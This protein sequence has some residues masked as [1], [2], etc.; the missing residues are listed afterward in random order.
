MSAN[1]PNP[2]AARQNDLLLWLAGALVAG[3]GVTWLLISSPWATRS[4]DVPR[5]APAAAA[6]AVPSNASGAASTASPPP[7]SEAAGSAAA[8]SGGAAEAAR[9]GAT[10]GLGTIDD[11]PLKMADLAY[12]AG[13]L[14]EPE[15]YSAWTLYRRALAKQP[16]NAAAKQG[17]EKIADELLRRATAAVEQGRFDDA[18][19]T[20][21]R[22]RAALPANS[23]ANDLAVKL[24]RLAPQPVLTEPP[25]VSKVV[26]AQAPLPAPEPARAE[27][28]ESK[29]AA[30]PKPA[31]PKVD[32]LA[33][34]HDAFVAAMAANRLLTPAASSAKHFVDALVAL[35][36]SS[37]V[38][39]QARSELAT[40]LLARAD[41]SLTTGD[42][43]AATT[44]IDQAS[45]LDV[46][47]SAVAAARQRLT[48]QLVKLESA[49]RLPTSEF[50]VVSYTAP[51]YPQRAL[52]RGLS[53]W[54]DVE[55]TI[56]RDGTT[57]DIVVTDAANEGYFKDAAVAAVRKW[58]FEPRVFMNRTIAQRT[59]TRINFNFK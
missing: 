25:R 37:D 50:K 32:R 14:V 46:D 4:P 36:P 16:D 19:K 10:T 8:D 12:R 57:R 59:Y 35:A 47:A 58:R 49:R 13:M 44:W 39:R 56:G 48:D 33:E 15:D 40:K 6:S 53:G 38:T 1:T 52:Q 18:R 45:S 11:D 55:F 43:D 17:L 34:A 41:E 31:E 9:Q 7:A 28:R 5:A 24:Q 30:S 29:P 27:A 3:V 54:I 2:V 26:R 22:I 21:D 51:V 42:T 23:G 20:I